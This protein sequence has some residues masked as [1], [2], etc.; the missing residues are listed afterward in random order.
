MKLHSLQDA[1]GKSL[2]SFNTRVGV[3]RKMVLLNFADDVRCVVVSVSGYDGDTELEWLTDSDQLSPYT[4][5]MLG[6]IGKDAY[7]RKIAESR[8]ASLRQQE[9]Q[10]RAQ[11]ERLKAKFEGQGSTS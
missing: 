1:V 6:L 5:L 11:Y 4:Q 3:S 7:E 8:K 10:E 2:L 9:E